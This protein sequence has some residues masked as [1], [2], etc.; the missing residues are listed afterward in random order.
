MMPIRGCL[1][2]AV[3]PHQREDHLSFLNGFHKALWVDKDNKA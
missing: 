2:R 3:R 1:F